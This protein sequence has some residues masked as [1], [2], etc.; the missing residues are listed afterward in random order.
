MKAIL[1]IGHG[2]RS[3]KGA[4]EAKSFIQRVIE[5]INVPIQEVSFLELTHP[6]I[7][8][9]F[10]RCVERG[11][12]EVTVVPLFLLAAGHIKEDIPN[13]IF[14]L[15]ENYPHI[16]IKVKD[17]FGVQGILLDGVAE[18]VR[19]TVSD[20]SSNDSI[21]IVGRG[22]SDPTIHNAFKEISLGI[23]QRLGIEHV[24]VCFL[25]A[26]EPR[27]DE[28]LENISSGAARRVI[29]VPYLL[30]SGL[31]LNEVNQKVLKRQNSG[32]RIVHTGQ[33]SKH[34]I[35]EDIVIQRAIE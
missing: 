12:T 35:I 11:A 24:L 33:L 4:E 30:F 26:A 34:R 29:V 8:E 13:T 25:A 21:L 6:F 15:R 19:D 27:L 16:P 1:Y 28:G 17:P 22:S 3:K 32:Q 10:R 2:T 31:L 23:R 20:L 9:G 14:A 18:L 5:R 7:E